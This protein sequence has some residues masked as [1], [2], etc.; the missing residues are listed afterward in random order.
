MKYNWEIKSLADI[1]QLNPKESIA[2]GTIAKKVPMDKLHLF[3]RDIPEYI[4]KNLT[5]EQNL[6]MA[7]R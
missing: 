7:I 3:C 5:V 2:K 4:L 1:V 6:E